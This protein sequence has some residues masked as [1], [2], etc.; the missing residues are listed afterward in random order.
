MSSSENRNAYIPPAVQKSMAAHMDRTMPA[1][2]KKYQNSGA[3]MPA[4]IENEM[5]AQMQKNLP[6]HMQQYV[7]PYMHQNVIY[8]AASS[9]PA[10]PLRTSAPSAQAYRP[11]QT[12]VVLPNNNSSRRSLRSTVSAQA[13]PDYNTQGSSGSPPDSDYEFI[14]NPQKPPKKPLLDLGNASTL[15]RAMFAGGALIVLIILVST[16]FSFLNSAGSDHRD[17]LLEI[18]QTQHE[19]IR[20]AESAEEK[21]GDRDLLFKVNNIQLTMRSSQLELIGAL[22]GRGLKKVEKKLEASQNAES[23]ALLVQGEQSGKFDETYQALLDQQLNNYRLQLQAAYESSNASE[24]QI[25][26]TAFGQIDL[27]LDKPESTQ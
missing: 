5:T 8:G 7:K 19:I 20:V 10:A 3:R 18:A 16:V 24:K 21:I 2:L 25:I 22:A 12:Q 1:H 4:R 15:K 26:E 14:M 27:L 23:D 6:A 9:A 13:P 11:V 17:R